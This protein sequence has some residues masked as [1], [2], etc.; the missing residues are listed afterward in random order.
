MKVSL[1]WLKEYLPTELSAHQ[2]AEKLTLTG[3]EVESVE[4]LKFS[5]QGVVVAEV[6]ETRAHPDADKLCVA[7]VSDGM[8]TF[9]VV[10][11][12]PNCRKGLKTA[13]APVGATLTDAKG[14]KILIEESELRGVFS[15]G[16]LCSADELGLPGGGL[17]I[18]E[19][20]TSAPLGTPLV[21]LFSDTQLEIAL[22][23]NLVHCANLR[24]LARELA[25]ITG[26]PLKFPSFAPPENGAQ[27]PQKSVTLTVSSPQASPR[28]ACRLITNVRV[29]PSP[30][31]LQRRLLTCGIR[32][33]NNVVDITNFVLL[34]CGQPLHAFD[35]AQLA[36]SHVVVRSAKEGESLVTLD[37]KERLLDP[38]V[39]VISDDEKPIALAGV[40][41][42]EETEVSEKTETILLESAYFEPREVR[43]TSRLFGLKTEAS[44]RFERGTDPNG[45]IEALER[46][47]SLLAELTGGTPLK[48]IVESSAQTFSPK[49]LSV[50]LHRIN[51][52]LG[53]QLSLSEVESL[54]S[55]IDLEI[56]YSSEEHLEV[57]APTYRHDLTQEIDLIEEVARLYGFDNIVHKS[58][59]KFRTGTL[60]HSPEY[61]SERGAKRKLVACGLQEVLTCDL[62]S[63]E[64]ASWIH[65][66]CIPSRNLIHLLNPSSRAHSVLRPSLLPG[67][68]EVV[69]T[70]IHHGTS[71]LHAFEV[72]RLHFTTKE[73]RPF[74]PLVASLVLTGLRSPYHFES[75]ETLVDFL[76][77]KGVVENLLQSFQVDLATFEASSFEN[78]HPSRQA[79]LRV[80]EIEIGHLG[81]IHPSTLQAAGIAQP[82]FFAELGLNDLE[83]ARGK[84]QKQMKP[85]PQFPASSRDWTVTLP[86]SLPVGQV[87]EQIDQTQSTLLESVLLLD[88][89]RSDALGSER[90]N[91]SFRFIYRSLEKTLSVKEVEAEHSRIIKTITQ[92]EDQL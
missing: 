29:A 47:A 62:I 21:T 53:T 56:L 90:K 51:T 92:N 82:V 54:L 48:G 66:N 42:G 36:G 39:L 57:A 40:M 55:R 75:K 86:E 76:D 69:K 85:L 91:V 67:L 74:E 43:K 28:Y 18:L 38:S 31:W 61:L 8:Q 46:A 1:N 71:T 9:S 13:L 34:E 24:G 20:P 3:L 70:N 27:S 12:A 11:G 33:I 83:A 49:K 64:Q 4:P 25:A 88:V 26:E 52:I 73:D 59:V 17:G 60:S 63:K 58:P 7:T 81:E 65:P 10:C 5:F 44:Y 79:A 84:K 16:M 41:G 15:S 45:V 78:F 30:L 19:L 50:R 72:G 14:K 23:P 77:L 89:Y 22:T 2:I 80:G 32:P 37:G 68:L 87:L 6:L 35:F